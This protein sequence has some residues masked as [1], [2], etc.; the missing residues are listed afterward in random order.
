[1]GGG[2]GR[3][4]ELTGAVVVVVV[5]ALQRIMKMR[6]GP[7]GRRCMAIEVAAC[8]CGFGCV[9]WWWHW[10]LCAVLCTGCTGPPEQT[11]FH[12]IK[13]AY[14]LPSNPR[15]CCNMAHCLTDPCAADHAS[16]P[17]HRRLVPGEFA[18]VNTTSRKLSL[19]QRRHHLPVG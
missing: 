3:L 18:T 19:H 16:T 5:P 17:T 11:P 8:S 6:K 9:W 13:D 1:M 14:A 12:D 15:K 4:G 7:W 10:G 2:Q